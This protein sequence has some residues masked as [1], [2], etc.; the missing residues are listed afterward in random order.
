MPIQDFKSIPDSKLPAELF[1]LDVLDGS[2][3]CSVFS[4]PGAREDKWGGEYAFREG[5]A[6]QQ[7]DDL[8][9]EFLEV[10][11]KLQPRV[12]VVENVKGMLIGKAH[13]FVSLV[14]SRLREIG[15]RP[16]LFLLN[17]ATMGV[18]QK[19]E[20]VFFIAAREDL[21]FPPLR[22]EFNDPPVLYKDIRSG[23]GRPINQDSLTFQRWHKKRPPDL[24]MGDVTEREE[25]KISNQTVEKPCL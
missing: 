22:L 20:R 11:N 21:P 24:N 1:N 9:F 2:P 5:Q 17:S 10:A 23:E 19:R 14:L 16:Q 3:P 6:V 15:Y 4:T 18:P 7:L 8:F 25:G 12:V 13:G